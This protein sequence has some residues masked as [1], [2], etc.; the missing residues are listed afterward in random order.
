VDRAGNIYIIG[1]NSGS[2]ET[3]T[4]NA[5]KAA[6]LK[7]EADDLNARIAEEQKGMKAKNGVAI[8]TEA[9]WTARIAA[10]KKE[11]NSKILEANNLEKQT[12]KTKENEAVPLNAANEEQL[13][14][15]FGDRDVDAA[16]KHAE[17]FRTRKQSKPFIDPVKP[18]SYDKVK[19][20]LPAGA[21]QA[22]FD[23]AM[24]T[25]EGRAYIESL[26]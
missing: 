1:P 19:A 23:E 7:A 21:T 5:G 17:Q 11:R 9:Q 12:T 16:K 15:L 10:L 14:Q 6:V 3:Q 22:D 18:I 20:K 26:K 2:I 8:E 4:E 24:K 25:P 13:R